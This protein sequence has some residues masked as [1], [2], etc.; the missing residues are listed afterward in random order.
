[1]ARGSA[2]WRQAA[3]GL[4]VVAGVLAL[5]SPAW[6]QQARV[7]LLVNSPRVSVDDELQVQVEAT[8]EFDELTSVTS[9]GFEFRSTGQQSQVQI[10]GGRIQ[11]IERYTWVG[12]PRQPGKYTLGPVELRNEGRSIAKS[13]AVE[14]EVVS[15]EAAA[16]PPVTPLEAADLRRHAGQPFFVRPSLST[17]SPYVGQPFVLTYELYWTRQV[18]IQG[19]RETSTPRWGR[20]DTEDLLKDRPEPEAV[21][22]GGRPY[23]RQITHK[24]LLTSAI[25]GPQRVEGPGFRIEGGDLFETRVTKVRAEPLEITVQP[26]PV[27]GRPPG[28]LDGN[29]G[30]LRLTAELTQ[31][32]QAATG[33]TRTV[34]TGERLMLAYT[35]E[36]EGNLLDLQTIQPPQV[37]G[38]AVEPLPGRADEAVRHTLAGT[39][40]KRTWQYVLSFSQ[41]GKFTLPAQP[42]AAF[43]PASE[44]FVSSQVEPFVIEVQGDP[45]QP[46]VTPSPLPGTTAAEPGKPTAQALSAASRLR[47]IAAEARLA[48]PTPGGW[49]RAPWFW[50]VAL[51]PWG[52]AALLG[53]SRILRRREERKAPERR[54]A[55]AL[56]EA[57]RELAAA[58]GSGPDRGY[59][60]VRTAVQA[61]LQ[62][63]A[64]VSPGLTE[65]QLADGL[66]RAGCDPQ[67]VDQLVVELQ[68]CDYARFAPGGDRDVDLQATA[69]RVAQVLERLDP[70]LRGQGGKAGVRAAGL[71]VLLALSAATL[72]CQ[73]A[74]L[75][76]TFAKANQAY[77]HG[78]PAAAVRAYESLLQHEVRSPALHYNLANALVKTGKLG[79]AVAQYKRALELGPDASLAAD[80]QHN[81]SLV[82]AELTDRARR[83]H[84]ILHIFDES[85]ELDV[86]LARAA[87]QRLLAILG[88]LAGWGAL[89]LLALRMLGRGDRNRAVWWTGLVL[90]LGLHAICLAWLVQAQ[91]VQ[92]TVVTA[93]VVEEDAT[94][95]PCQG[96]GES[97]GLPEGLEVRRLGEV[98]DGRQEVRLPN[99]RTGCVPRQALTVVG[100][101]GPN[102]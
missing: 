77:V 7:R 93:V 22:I 96:V 37:P 68:H 36:G 38:M 78:D 30:R 35:V 49:T 70:A 23:L 71:A 40:G 62:R 41:P 17:A 58:R 61:Y 14:V 72:P 20:F 83:K 56:D 74:T 32:G 100:V 73:A 91:H 46:V 11:R 5:V 98:A 99:G 79:E 90:C 47:P 102:P 97:I 26:V 9:E 85:P 8:G 92:A 51:L 29:V 3:L 52:L 75:D 4:A 67:A 81:L 80:V 16:G 10:S 59:A 48:Q 27:A 76:E 63:V 18:R 42:W 66:R 82:R 64:A 101:P 86:A 65:S 55:N 95:A 69:D 60:A 44:Q 12:T 31:P 45:S 39:E 84:A 89:A 6:A 19:I 2:R 54:R 94:L 28:F 15:D 57:R 13:N 33:T 53:L 1:M 34:K 21:A 25:A 50:A 88:L 87:P 24:V 43:D